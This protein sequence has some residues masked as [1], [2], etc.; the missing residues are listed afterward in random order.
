MSGGSNRGGSSLRIPRIEYL[1]ARPIPA[2]DESLDSFMFRAANLNGI[3]IAALMG[4][5]RLPRTAADY[6]MILQH[7]AHLT[8][9]SVS[10]I[11]EM[12]LD[13]CH[14]RVLADDGWAAAGWGQHCR[15]APNGVVRRE[16][17][18]ALSP[19]CFHCGHLIEMP[20]S[21]TR[22][23][24]SAPDRIVAACTEVSSAAHRSAND[25]DALDRLECLRAEL[26]SV[27]HRLGRV[28]ALWESSDAQLVDTAAEDLAMKREPE[29]VLPRSPAVRALAIT[30][31]WEEQRTWVQPRVAPHPRPIPVRT[32][33]SGIH[34]AQVFTRRV[35][36]TGARTATTMR[37]P[38]S[39]IRHPRGEDLIRLV[40]GYTQ[41]NADHIP[42]IYR[43][44]GDPLVL[45]PDEWLWRSRVAVLLGQSVRLRDQWS[46]ADEPIYRLS[47]TGSFWLYKGAWPKWTPMFYRESDIAHAINMARGLCLDGMVNYR[48]RRDALRNLKLAPPDLVGTLPAAARDFD[49]C[50]RLAA[51]W[52]WFDSTCDSPRTRSDVERLKGFDTALNPEGRL[53]LRNAADVLCDSTHELVRQVG[54]PHFD[55]AT[56]DRA[57]EVGR[58]REG[59]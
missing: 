55:V 53:I 7:L 44:E 26:P 16:W 30:M 43:Q 48:E 11:S 12:T 4:R 25:S 50:A 28:S 41:L 23:P 40:L 51:A 20:G 36:R 42:G 31:I 22:R 59:A 49:G 6:P 47:K 19:V 52:M 15:C 18:L 46:L 27:A 38:K 32:V 37:L 5:S 33:G 1:P 34:D 24:I 13:D 10:R 2:D 3:R 8:R 35:L 56:P 39:S 21:A 58:T 57:A 17:A 9:Q 54:R 29:G 45:E 14:D